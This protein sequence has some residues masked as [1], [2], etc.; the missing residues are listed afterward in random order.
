MIKVYE[1]VAKHGSH[2][3]ASHAGGKG[4]AGGSGAEVG[5]AREDL[6]NRAQ[7]AS[8]LRNRPSGLWTQEQMQIRDDRLKG[9]ADG[10]K[11]AA[12]QVGNPTKMGK[13]R[14]LM[15]DS[16]NAYAKGFTDAVTQAFND[17][18]TLQG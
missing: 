2:N 1:Y 3:Q 16:D 7:G 14:E 12:N 18:G 10:Y 15:G 4:G 13:L 17:Y 6:E 11:A 9:T 8:D 5:E